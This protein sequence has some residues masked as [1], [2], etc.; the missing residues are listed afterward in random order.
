[1][2]Y[3]ISLF[4]LMFLKIYFG[5]GDGNTEEDPMNY[6]KKSPMQQH[7]HIRKKKTEGEKKDCSYIFN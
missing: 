6:K 3:N 2:Y 1:M 7:K 4:L 5:M